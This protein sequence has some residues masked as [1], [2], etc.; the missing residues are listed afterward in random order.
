MQSLWYAYTVVVEKK[1]MR[2]K[3][4][5]KWFHLSLSIYPHFYVELEVTG[6]RVNREGG[7]CLEILARF[8]YYGPEKATQC[9]ETGLTKMK[10]QKRA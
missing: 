9:L 1:F 4:F 3:T 6:K 10:K 5:Q 8:R 2:H 7:Y